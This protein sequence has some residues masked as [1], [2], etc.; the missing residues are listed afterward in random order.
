MTIT[1][2]QFGAMMP[3][4]GA[5]LD[6]HWPFLNVALERAAITTPE[7]IAAFVA[8]LAHESGEYRY[9]EELA[10][11]SAYE[12]RA[13]LGNTEPGDGMKFRGHGP[14]QITGRANHK[15]CGE[16]M[17]LDLI[18]DPRLI[19]TPEHGTASACWFWNAKRL[20]P[21]ADLGWFTTISK[22]INGGTNG[23]YDRWRY[24]N[25]NRELLGL[26]Q[27]YPIGE[28]DKIRTWQRDHGLVADGV[29]GPKTLA[30]VEA[31]AAMVGSASD[32][33]VAPAGWAP[34]R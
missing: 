18:A 22:I 14:I 11:G 13:D 27:L 1:R 15:A 6:A 23:L 29:V 21:L 7:R 16:A 9:M 3:G 2:E 24:Y 31:E 32:R 10:D 26:P 34:G 4:A 20:S 33:C 30:A 17:G 5:R 28:V 25:R 19:C 8:Q 12:G